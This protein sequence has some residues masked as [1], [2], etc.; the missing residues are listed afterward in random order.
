MIT[1]SDDVTSITYT[2]GTE[3]KVTWVDNEERMPLESC[4]FRGTTVIGYSSEYGEL[5]RE[6]TT[7]PTD[8]LEQL[9]TVVKEDLAISAWCDGGRIFVRY[10]ESAEEITKETLVAMLQVEEEPKKEVVTGV[11]GYTRDSEI[12]EELVDGELPTATL[13]SMREFMNSNIA[14]VSI[15]WRNGK[16]QIRYLNDVVEELTLEELRDQTPEVIEFEKTEDN[17]LVGI[18][19]SIDRVRTPIYSKT[20]QLEV[21]AIDEIT[22]YLLKFPEISRITYDSESKTYTVF[23]RETGVSYNVGGI[24]NL[25][26]ATS[27]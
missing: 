24:E 18:D 23:A 2:G 17:N 15:V 19:M 26:S 1:E 6:H 3:I 16:T 8:I 12:V 11:I 25:V 14:V 10:P 7:S 27:R 5:T 22:L 20:G 13:T 4:F 9:D 21:T